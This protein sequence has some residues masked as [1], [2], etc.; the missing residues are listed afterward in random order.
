MGRP[1]KGLVDSRAA[2]DSRRGITVLD[3][4]GE[5]VVPDW[6]RENGEGGVTSHVLRS[7]GNDNGLCSCTFSMQNWEIRLS[8]LDSVLCRDAEVCP[9]CRRFLSRRGGGLAVICRFEQSAGQGPI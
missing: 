6:A 7:F 8:S 5:G 9:R 2:R 3:V 4:F 1:C